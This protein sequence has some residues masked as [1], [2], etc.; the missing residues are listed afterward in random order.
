MNPV[1]TTRNWEFINKVYSLQENVVNPAFSLEPYIVDYELYEFYPKL[2][3][4]FK[5][6]LNKNIIAAIESQTVIPLLLGDPK[7]V[8]D[9]MIAHGAVYPSFMRKRGKSIV[10]FVDISTKAKYARN[11]ITK[12]IEALDNITER[13]FYAFMQ[14]GYLNKVFY[15]NANAFK[16]N[17]KFTKLVAEIYAYMMQKVISS[18]YPVTA[19]VQDAEI[20]TYLCAV[21]CFQNFFDYDMEKA[22]ESALSLKGVTKSNIVNNCH[23]YLYEE[24]D[25]LDMRSSLQTKQP[26]N[27]KERIYPIDKFVNILTLEFPYI[28]S[29]KVQTRT[30]F[31]R[32]MS[33]YGANSLLAVEH[34]FS[35]INMIMTAT[36]RINLFTDLLIEKAAG[37]YVDNLQKIILA[38]IA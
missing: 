15:D 21:F 38:T 13:D 27:E 3:K 33:M 6:P 4:S 19:T 18:V 37:S 25:L 2:F 23:Y 20:L 5:Y 31:D 9:K 16:Y 32:Y 7:D 17:L 36:M 34:G 26:E 30:I 10:S 11:K 24:S 35:F 1:N 28:K 22:R 14:M 12:G 8:G 29:G